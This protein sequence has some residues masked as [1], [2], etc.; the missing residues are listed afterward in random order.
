MPTY[1]ITSPTG[2]VFEITA[3]E[4]ASQADIM[5]YAQ[6]QMAQTVP[7]EVAP[8]APL[9]PPMAPAPPISGA[10]PGG[11]D[12]GFQ[13]P[14][15]AAATQPVTP[16]PGIP[17]AEVPGRAVEAFPEVAVVSREEGVREADFPVVVV[18][19]VVVRLIQH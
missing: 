5:S 7:A 12:L 11:A 6:S 16:Q 13:D 3:P 4:G 9:A 17:W 18:Q 19:E 14:G 15:Y 10:G 2:E 1:E 8:T